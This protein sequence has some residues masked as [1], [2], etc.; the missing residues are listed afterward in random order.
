MEIRL[1]PLSKKRVPA[2]L[3][4]IG[5]FEGSPLSKET[6]LL[7]PDFIPSVKAAV[8]R[9]RFSGKFGET[10]SAY[11]VELKE[12]SE[13]VV[14]GLGKKANHKHLC[15]RKAAAT[16]VQIAQARKAQHVRVLLDSF[17]GGDVTAADAAAAFSEIANLTTYVFDKYKTQPANEEKKRCLETVELLYAKGA[18]EAALK[19]SVEWAGLVAQGTLMARNLINEPGNILTAAKMVQ[20]AEDLAEKKAVTVKVLEQKELEEL[21]MGGILGVNQGSLNPPALI[22]LEYGSRYKKDG[23]VCL[24]GKGVTFDTGGI[25]IK[26]SKDMEKMKYDMSGSAAVLSTMSALADAKLPVHVVGLMPMVENNVNNNPMRPGDIIRMYNGK[27]VEV[28]NTDAEGRL[29]LAD[30][31]S[32]SERYQP[33]VIIDLATLT[34]MC[35]ATF[36]DKAIGM[37]GNDEKMLARVKKAGETAGQRCWELPLWD[38]YGEQIKGHH[39]DLYNI[40]GPYGGT[41]TA[42]MFLKEF[43]PAKTP[44]VHLDIAGTAWA[45]APRFD[46]VK[47]ATGVGVKLLMQFLSDWV[48]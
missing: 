23:T 47:G 7:E 4:V 20:A 42:A 25:S 16:V 44:W 5:Y 14:L 8:E 11:C 27:T 1:T 3:L 21:K 36:G 24:V 41:I 40:G 48:K 43:I 19:K 12:A 6:E 2:D 18:S 37:L 15:I 35:A 34:G 46:C 28:L 13:T 45:D 10:V 31:L 22:I 38:E 26:P 33:K 9:K 32:Y 39:S 29:I 30:A 17:V